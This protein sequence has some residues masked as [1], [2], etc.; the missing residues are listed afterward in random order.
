[1]AETKE[2]A[3][4]NA[5]AQNSASSTSS[6]RSLNGKQ[7]LQKELDPALL[8]A[9]AQGIIQQQE[10]NIILQASNPASIESLGRF[11]PNA[12]DLLLD[13]LNQLSLY[14]SPAEVNLRS[15]TSADPAQS[16]RITSFKLKLEEKQSQA[17][18]LFL[19]T[20]AE[21]LHSRFAVQANYVGILFKTAEEALKKLP[22]NSEL[23]G[24]MT[25]L[26][27][28][29][30][31]LQPKLE[32]A[33]KQLSP[34][35]TKK[36]PASA[37]ELEERLTGVIS[38]KPLQKL[39]SRLEQVQK[40]V[41][42]AYE[43]IQSR[44]DNKA[45]IDGTFDALVGACIVIACFSTWG[46]ATPF[47]A[48]GRAVL[49]GMGAFAAKDV[50]DGLMEVSDGALTPKD[51]LSRVLGNV[52]TYAFKAGVPALS[53][54]TGLL[55][56][57]APILRGLNPATRVALG[58]EFA[59]VSAS[60]YGDVFN[61]RLP[62]L[63][64]VSWAYLNGGLRAAFFGPFGARM[65]QLQSQLIRPNDAWKLF[66]VEFATMP[67]ATT[68]FENFEHGTQVT[69]RS[70]IESFLHN[71]PPVLIGHTLNRT[72]SPRRSPLRVDEARLRKHMEIA[73]EMGLTPDDAMALFKE[74]PRDP[75]TGFFTAPDTMTILEPGLV[76]HLPRMDQ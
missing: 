25:E 75:V 48:T 57:G 60:Q 24:P 64:E 28:L 10:K 71:A 73:T 23:K 35:L 2:Q 21:E 27:L 42:D 50:S 52:P 13:S 1:M 4:V 41:S 31:E 7:Q 53:A 15:I 17:R 62:T 70:I 44:A 14:F 47:I 72:P 18:Q 56:K 40:K 58:Y 43:V 67:F 46:G 61:G 11:S 54:G 76:T 65:G 6:A 63:Q 51:L 59:S 74:A 55:A 5:K 32:W 34:L 45:L 19:K 9:S 8:S 16:K 66:A 68:T 49:L 22:P 26:G 39:F 3:S 69:S 30:R 20:T 37:I 33:V 38:Y 29:V 36:P 12:K